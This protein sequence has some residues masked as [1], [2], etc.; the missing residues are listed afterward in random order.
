V[1]IVTGDRAA[2][3]K[4]LTEHD[5]IAAIWYFGT[6]EG[7]AAVE[8][9]SIGNLKATWVNY[10]KPVAWSEPASQGRDYLRRA[11]QVKNIWVPYGE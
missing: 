11:T 10:G 7:S 5:D 1:N 3:S 9:G 6:K 8:A 2:L 4:T